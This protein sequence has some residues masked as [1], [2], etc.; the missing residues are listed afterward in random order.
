MKYI[1]ITLTMLLA[2]MT[3]V[4]EVSKTHA[5]SVDI[6]KV[7]FEDHLGNVIYS[8]HVVAGAD[9]SDLKLPEAPDR[10]GYIF[11][12]WSGELPHEMPHADLVYI[13]IYMEQ[14]LSLIVNVG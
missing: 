9:L 4:L 8:E 13:A 12:G 14:S 2:A 7:S 11:V 1:I 10:P 6:Q 5:T 3:F